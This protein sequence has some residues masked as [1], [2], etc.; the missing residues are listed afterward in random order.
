MIDTKAL[1]GKLRQ[2]R[3]DF[4]EA[5]SV[6]ELVRATGDLLERIR[7]RNG[8]SQAKVAN[9]LGISPGR[10]S[11]LESGTIRNAPSLKTIA[12][13]ARACGEVVDIGTVSERD[14]QAVQ[15]ATSSTVKDDGK[16]GSIE[17]KISG[18]SREIAALRSMIET[19]YRTSSTSLYSPKLPKHDAAMLGLL[20]FPKPMRPGLEPGHAMT[21]YMPFGVD[22]EVGH[23]IGI[24]D[25]KTLYGVE[26]ATKSAIEQAANAG[27]VV[28]TA[29]Q[30]MGDH[31]ELT[32]KVGP[33]VQNR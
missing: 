13:F 5:H 32:F 24:I 30:D 21:H 28:T 2:E 7:V 8:L 33:D 18:I 20:G 3:P 23:V 4:D 17:N 29:T 6:V 12:Q 14:S 1:I 11:Q 9:E 19:L 31:I 15:D 22:P 27:V 26:L 16:L 25:A 10:I